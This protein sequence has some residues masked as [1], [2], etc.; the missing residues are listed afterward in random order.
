M[1]YICSMKRVLLL[2]TLIVATVICQARNYDFT[3]QRLSTINGLP[4]NIVTRIW[5]DNTGYVCIETANGVCRYD[6]YSVTQINNNAHHRSIRSEVLRTRDAEWVR[7]GAGKLER[8]GKNNAKQSWQLIPKDVIAYTHND[9][10][11]VADVDDYTEA[12]S[13]YG[14]GLFLYDKRTGE[15]TRI[16]NDGMKDYPFLTTLFVDNTGCI[17]VAADYLGILCIRMNTQNY[18][19]WLLVNNA[20]INDNNHIRSIARLGR[21]TLC[22]GNQL[23]DIYTYDTQKHTVNF[24]KHAPQRVYSTMVDRHGQLWIGTRGAGLWVDNE[25]IKGLPSPH[26]YKIMEDANGNV[27]VAM[28]Q[29]GVAIIG[30]KG[31]KTLLRGKNC[32][33]M[34]FDSKGQWWVA[35]EDSLYVF[36]AHSTTLSPRGVA[37]GYFVCLCKDVNGNIWAGSIGKGILKYDCSAIEPKATFYSTSNGLPNNN[38][39][40]IVEDTK[41]NIWVGTEDG[42]SYINPTTGDTRNLHFPISPLANVFNERAAVCLSNGHLMFGTHDGLIEIEPEATVTNN[43]LPNTSITSFVI[44][45]ENSTLANADLNYKEHNLTFFFSNFQYSSL[46]SV[47]YQ[48]WLEGFDTAWCQPTNEHSVIYRKLPPGHYVFHVRSNNGMGQWGKETTYEFTINPPLWNTWWAW[49]VY[50]LLLVAIITIVWRTS[51]RILT[52]HRQIDVERR[53]SAFKKDFYDRIERELSNPVTV[54]HGASENVKINGTSKT[55][56][57]SLRR[58]SKRMMRIMD[59][60]R[61]FHKLND[62]EIQV[63]AEADSINVETEERFRQIVSCIHAEETEFREM[64]PPPINHITILIIEDDEDNLT[65]LTD[66]LNPYF[67][68]IGQPQLEECESMIATHHPSLILLD[69]TNDEKAGYELT[70]RVHEN[71][72]ALPVIHL[73]FYGDDAHQLRSLRSGATDYIVKPFSGQVLLER[74]RSVLELSAHTN[75]ADKAQEKKEVLT[76]VKDKKFLDRMTSML[77]AHIG[78]ENFS[79]EQ[80][81]E[82]MNLGRTQFYKRVKELTGETPVQHLHSARLE[83]AAGLLKDTNATIEEIMLKAGYRNATYFYNSFKKKYGMSPKMYRRCEG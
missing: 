65:H 52:L 76:D 81:A 33:D 42:L 31:V 9:H 83:Y 27:R 47:L 58:G 41:G 15:L 54:L 37:A 77:L 34:I 74:V 70:H 44:N 79:V 36:D 21:N 56:V 14:S 66:T 38:V 53:V 64:A 80:W 16:I 6:G 49:T 59:M 72:P 78:E 11:H 60:I 22:I 25:N 24:M 39:Y 32:H 46:N 51:R 50:S 30:N 68:V 2:L 61:Q 48:Y 40:S 29:G 23:G 8:R 18:S 69:I 71:L 17:W 43:T 28:L 62:M 63:K 75:S 3:V 4:T 5:Q 19:H 13:T 82:T 7:M 26:I 20:T 35:A 12:I 55:T 73:S 10:F 67:R 1:Y 45:G 57:Q